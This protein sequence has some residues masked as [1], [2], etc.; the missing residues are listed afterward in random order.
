MT[1]HDR[2]LSVAKK[3]R[4]QARVRAAARG[5]DL[6]T[7]WPHSPDFRFGTIGEDWQA[8]GSD[9]RKAIADFEVCD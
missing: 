3:A 7:I 1:F 4:R 2:R 9:M 5:V 8:V 6:I